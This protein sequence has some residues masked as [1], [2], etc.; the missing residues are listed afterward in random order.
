VVLRR[1]R[2]SL[3]SQCLA[4]AAKSLAFQVRSLTSFKVLQAYSSHRCWLAALGALIILPCPTL[5]AAAPLG[6]QP[7]PAIGALPHLRAAVCAPRG[8]RQAAGLAR[9]QV[10]LQVPVLLRLGAR[11]GRATEGGNGQGCC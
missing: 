2:A 11:C 10:R 1:L 3:W 4:L 9:L 6:C 5:P 8:H 7:W